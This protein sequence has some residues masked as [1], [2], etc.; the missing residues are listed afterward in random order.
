MPDLSITEIPDKQSLDQALRRGEYDLVITDYELFWSDGLKIINRLKQENPRVPVVM[1]TG[2][3]NEEVAVEAMKAG[4]LD[5]ITKSPA[6][7]HRLRTSVLQA[8][9]R[10]KHSV[11]LARAEQRYKE[12][13]DSVPVGLFR[14]TPR[15][16]I[17]DA[18]PAFRAMTGTGQEPADNFEK[19]HAEAGGFQSWRE[20]LER[21][22]AVACVE[23]R[24]IMPDES[25]RW[26]E[27]HAKAVRDPE[28]EEI[29]YEGSVED[30]SPRK[31][32]DAE[33]ESLIDELREALGRVK[34]LTGLLPICSSCK[35]I[36]DTAGRW[37]MLESFIENHSH[38]HFTHSFCPEC[39]RNLY[40]EVFLDRV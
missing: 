9:E 13:F 10:I 2:S 29:V 12:L 6:H 25:I 21:D 30:I 14:C 38:A 19:L 28:T 15:G 40:P 34:T 20:K 36:R 8:F 23:T 1:F 27:I 24:F 26:V 5:Y 32:T 17:I 33:R 31:R 16:E 22:G 3:G 4:V 39:A 11:E 7:F 18:N 37:T 35:K